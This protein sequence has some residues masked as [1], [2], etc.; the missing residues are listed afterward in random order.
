METKINN[1]VLSIVFLVN[2]SLTVNGQNS[3]NEPTVQK[4]DS[5]STKQQQMLKDYFFCTCIDY[6]F[7]GDSLF[8]KDHSLTVYI[9]MLEYDYNDI[10]RVKQFAKQVVNEIPV[11][12]YSGKR[13]VF[14]SC[15]EYYRGKELDQLIKSMK[16]RK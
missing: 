11:S 10:F 5:T 8:F 7:K 13:G 3:T 6:G 1:F 15:I 2:L 12:N 14:G 16:I 4:I 9:E